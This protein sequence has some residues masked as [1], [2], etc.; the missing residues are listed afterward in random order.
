MANVKKLVEKMLR[1]PPEMR[2]TEV[3]SVLNRIWESW[4]S[5]NNNTEEA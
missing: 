5:V 2:F 1:L 4:F 3:T